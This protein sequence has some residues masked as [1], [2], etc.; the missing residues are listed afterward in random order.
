[1]LLFG[2]ESSLILLNETAEEAFNHLL[3]ANNTCSA[4]HDKL[5]KMLKARFNIKKLNEAWLVE[6]EYDNPELLGAT[7]TAI[8]VN[9][10]DT[11]TLAERI[12]MLNDDQRHI[13]DKIKNYLFH[14]K[15]HEANDCFPRGLMYIYIYI[16]FLVSTS[17]VCVVYVVKEVASFMGGSVN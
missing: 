15:Q 7:K 6:G 14:Q 9:T 13:F 11:L 12:T 10:S 5:Q 16:F 2:N 4:Y 1:M 17:R 8:N 3:P